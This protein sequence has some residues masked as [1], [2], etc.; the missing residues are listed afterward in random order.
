LKILFVNAIDFT[1]DIETVYPPLGLAYLSS[2]IKKQHP[3]IEIKIID[4]NIKEELENFKPDTVGISA[5]SQNYGVAI[6]IAGICR[7][8]N[9]PVFIGGV[10]ISLLPESLDKAFDFGVY[11]E[12]EQT[13][14][15]IVDLL[16][17][18]KELTNANLKNIKGLIL[19]NDDAVELTEAR[20]LISNLDIIPFPDRELLNIPAGQTTYMFTS[21]GCPYK[22]AFCASTRFW[23]NVR[24]FS[25]EYV[26]NEIEDV[27]DKYKP[28]AISFYDDLFIANLSRLESITK[29]ICEKGIHNKVKFSFACRANLVNEKL[30]EILR[31]LDIQMICMGLESGCQ[32]TL[33]YLKGDGMTVEHNLRAIDLFSKAKINAQG[34]FIIGSPEETEEDILETL[35]FIRKSKL[36][37]FDIYILSPFPGTPIWEVAERKG[38]V[39]KA[40]DWRQLAVDFDSD[41]YDRIV[42]SDIPK[43]KLKKLHA[44]FN[45]ERKKRKVIYFFKSAIKNPQRIISK[46]LSYCRL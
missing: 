16:I 29:L 17:N 46:L 6:E 36:V 31:P 15:E 26:V 32:K 11:G 5:V 7:S 25:A 35:K 41:I 33:N 28:W 34:T 30:I 20:P 9:V 22:C 12:A 45:R 8:Y 24:W 19:H 14:L 10:H 37:N 21:R 13:I 18:R 1:R 39:S 2:S 23:D 42:L 44:L 40:M 3:H 27:I 4:R 38:L 43:Q